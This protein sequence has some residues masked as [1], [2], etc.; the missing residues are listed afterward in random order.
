M[1]DM[2]LSSGMTMEDFK[3]EMARRV[4]AEGRIK[5]Q[6]NLAFGN[7]GRYGSYTNALDDRLNALIEERKKAGGTAPFSAVDLASGGGFFVEQFS[8]RY[9]SGIEWHPTERVAGED[10]GGIL[11]KETRAGLRFLA[12]EAKEVDNVLFT[13]TNG[14]PVL[15]EDLVVLQGLTRTEFNGLRGVVVHKDSKNE[16]RFAVIV[17][18][19]GRDPMSFKGTNLIMMGSPPHSVTLE[20]SRK[21]ALVGNGESDDFYNGLL[22]RSCEVDFLIRETWNNVA[23]LNGKCLVV[24]ATSILTCM[25]YREP[26]VW[27]EIMTLASQL[28]A[29]KGLLL[30]YDTE[31]WGDFANVEVMKAYVDANSLGLKLEDRS[32]PVYFDD[33]E[34][35]MFLLLWQKM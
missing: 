10:D 28:L 6:R 20:H 34:G 18:N 8:L 30:Q 32:E 22:E 35:R 29:P 33:E 24:T 27:Q 25:G 7:N 5:H 17:E 21:R 3:K 19:H 1:A 4:S 13:D 16:G 26:L 14:N 31:K 23:H 2:F 11:E 15:P 12:K 9:Y